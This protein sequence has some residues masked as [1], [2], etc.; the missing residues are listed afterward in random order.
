ALALAGSLRKAQARRDGN[1]V[2]PRSELE[3]QL[4]GI[5][6]DVLELIQIGVNQ[7]IFALGADSIKVTQTLSR[8][9]AQLCIHL[10]FNHIFDAPT[11]AAL[12]ARIESNRG[13]PAVTPGLRDTLAD[14][15]KAPLSYQQKRIQVLSRLD[16]TGYNYNVLE[17]VR[18]LGPLDVDALAASIARI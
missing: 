11:V 8:L 13:S 7:N 10:S 2:E 15:R 3:R 16:P 18:L 4:S 5:W 9:R 12:A 17:V 14:A 1:M 6:M